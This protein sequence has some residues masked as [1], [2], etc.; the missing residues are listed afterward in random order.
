M[1]LADQTLNTEVQAYGKNQVSNVSNQNTRTND[2]DVDDQ[3]LISEANA[4]G[5][6]RSNY[7]TSDYTSAD[8]Q[9]LLS[10]DQYSA[11]HSD[12]YDQERR[13]SAIMDSGEDYQSDAQDPSDRYASND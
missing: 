11:L 13:Q 3:T 4:Y 1:S 5:E 2:G 8:D 7:V 6:N 10:T 9:T 12:Y